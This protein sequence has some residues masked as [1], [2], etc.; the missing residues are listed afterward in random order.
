MVY[1]TSCRYKSFDVLE[2]SC[3]FLL[4][5][6]HKPYSI[7]VHS[8]RGNLRLG[9]E[10]FERLLGVL[11]FETY[12]NLTVLRLTQQSQKQKKATDK[13]IDT[14]PRPLLL[15]PAWTNSPRHSALIISLL[16]EYDSIYISCPPPSLLFPKYPFDPLRNRL[17]IFSTHLQF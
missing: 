4:F 11:I 14:F 8:T 6:A 10:S 1:I 16:I 12:V 17:L 15:L 7:E 3:T 9:C 2:Y 5:N 13:S